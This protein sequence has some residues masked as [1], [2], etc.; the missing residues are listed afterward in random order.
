MR[1]EGCGKGAANVAGQS[2]A[3]MKAGGG[4][5]QGKQERK[6]EGEEEG[7]E[8]RGSGNERK[9]GFSWVCDIFSLDL[10]CGLIVLVMF[11]V[12]SSML[13]FMPETL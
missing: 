9:E 12:L 4:E 2:W 10:G 5:V 6:E 13:V 11:T 1:R 8:R 3:E 7:N